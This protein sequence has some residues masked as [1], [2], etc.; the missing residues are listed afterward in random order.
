MLGAEM[1]VSRPI[2]SSGLAPLEAGENY[3]NPY[4]VDTRRICALRLQQR[5]YRYM[6]LLLISALQS[7]GR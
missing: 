3:D 7:R 6:M 2:N 1:E 4:R 5:L